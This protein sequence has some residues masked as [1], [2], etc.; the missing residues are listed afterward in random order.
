MIVT[1]TSY[2]VCLGLLLGLYNPYNKMIK[3]ISTEPHLLMMMVG[4][5]GSGKSMLVADLL[6]N[7]KYFNQVLI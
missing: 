7:E 3:R 6:V 1:T 5:S 2:L 4:P